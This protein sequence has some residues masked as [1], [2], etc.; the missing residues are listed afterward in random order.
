MT[1]KPIMW[2]LTLTLALVLGVCWQVS[3]IPSN[4]AAAQIRPRDDPP[5]TTV[6]WKSGGMTVS[7][8]GSPNSGETPAQFSA[9]FRAEVDALTVQFPQ[10]P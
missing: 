9:R 4:V 6:S 7:H 5:M 2:L 10:D 3:R 1:N 8:S